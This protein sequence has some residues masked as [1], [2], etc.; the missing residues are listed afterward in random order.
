MC[1]LI[2][3]YLSAY[4]RTQHIVVSVIC[5][6]QARIFLQG[7]FL[8]HSISSAQYHGKIQELFLSQQ[9]FRADPEKMQ[10]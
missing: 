9:F 10:V 6:T 7:M 2:Y 5:S 8:S 4:F 3:I 1:A